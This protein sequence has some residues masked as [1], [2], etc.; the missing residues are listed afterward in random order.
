MF[1]EKFGYR[2]PF[3]MEDITHVIGIELVSLTLDQ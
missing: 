3:M 2:R 1:E